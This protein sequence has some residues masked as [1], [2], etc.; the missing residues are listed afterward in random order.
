[1]KVVFLDRDGTVIVDP[2]DERVD[3]LEKIVLFPDS[4]KALKYLADNDFAVV[5]IT[6]QAGIAEGRISEDGFWRIH[7][8]VLRQLEPSGV[9]V[10]KTYMNGEAAGPD[11]TEWRK[12]GPKM[13]LQASED[14]SLD[15]ANIYM[16][17]DSESDIYAAINA[18]CKG[19]VLVET[20]TN[21]KAVAQD[22]V[23]CAAN[24]MDAVKFVVN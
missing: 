15:L 23:Y 7:N 18:R 21:R 12:P 2:Q 1:M 4:I 17:G 11:S 5:F 6:N 20:A 13:L 19:G 24:L 9:K 10:L 8:E 22:A 16:V 14:L 3:R